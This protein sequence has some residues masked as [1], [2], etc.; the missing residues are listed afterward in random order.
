MSD[1]ILHVQMTASCPHSAQVTVVTSNTRVKVGDQYA[2][3]IA[4]TFTIAGCPYQVPVGAGTK[5]QPCTTIQWL[6]GATRVKVMG[7]AVVLKTSTGLCQS[8]DQ[9]PA[10]PPTISQT[11]TRVKGT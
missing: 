7:Q 9:I 4:D 1:P 8:A 6:V 11:Q 2:A 10:G 3:T 5:P